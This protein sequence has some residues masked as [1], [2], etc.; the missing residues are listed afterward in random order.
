MTANAGRAAWAA[1]AATLVL[2]ACTSVI[3][4]APQRASLAPSR[5]AISLEPSAPPPL[6]G[7]AFDPVRVAEVLGPAVGTVIVNR[8]NGAGEGTGFVVAHGNN[9]SYMVTNNHVVSG[10]SSVRVLMPD[11]RH[12]AAVIHGADPQG[13]LAV[14]RIDAANL[15]LATFGDSSKLRVG[16][17]VVAIGSSLGNEGSV[18]VGVI[19]A[20]HRSIAAGGRVSGPSESLPDVLQTDAAINPGNSGGPLAD[21]QGQVVGVNTAASAGA[22]SIGFAIPSVVARRTAEA[23]IAGKKPGHPYLGVSY[24]SEQDALAAGATFDGF[25]VLVRQVVRGC[26]ADKA[27]IH[28]GDVIQQVDGVDLNRGQTLGGV[29]QLH[30]PGDRV[31]IIVGRDTAKVEL[32][33]TLADRPTNPDGPCTP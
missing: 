31:K 15:P 32:Q 29:L 17:Q 8:P 4:P 19:S 27:G 22:N 6:S 2:T 12:F 3:S 20:L 13:D 14:L 33:A 30:S 11:G 25:G 24:Q 28:G 5:A 9:V 16:Q 26:P 21:A 23:L 10:A 18:T 7:S 1:V